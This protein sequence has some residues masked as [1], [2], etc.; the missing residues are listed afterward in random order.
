MPRGL[1]L[2]S[3]GR[4]EGN[5]EL[6]AN[7]AMAGAP[8]VAW[9]KL[10]LDDYP[11][12]PF[13][14]VRHASERPYAYPEGHAAALLDHTLAADLLLLAAP[15]YW[16]TLPATAKLYLDHWSH[17]MR[18]PEVDFRR[19]MSGKYLYATSAMAGDDAAEFEGISLPL[20]RTAEY[21]GMRWGGMVYA[22]ANAAGDVLGQPE[23]LAEARRLIA[24]TSA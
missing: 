13:H 5:A 15:L 8:H 22:H 11:L 18:V 10:Y 7:E 12:P 19:R 16:Y 1:I 4:R 6:L 23:V 3:S 14:D 9:T 2:V 24:A 21:M 17:W 20:K